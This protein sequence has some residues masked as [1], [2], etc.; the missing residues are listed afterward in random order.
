MAGQDIYLEAKSA[1]ARIKLSA[2]TLAKMRTYGNGPRYAK[3]GGKILY[4]VAD[5]DGWIETHFVQSTHDPRISPALSRQPE[6]YLRQKS[7]GKKSAV[8]P[9]LASEQ[10]TTTASATDSLA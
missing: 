5:L 2:A 6:D 1:A 7:A 3:V 9:S 10:S 4:K 8:E